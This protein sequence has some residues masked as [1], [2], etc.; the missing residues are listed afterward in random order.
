MK[1]VI[2]KCYGGFSLS[3]AAYDK[4]EVEFD[5]FGYLDNED[6]GIESQ[7]DLAYRADPRVIAVIEELGE[8]TSSGSMSQLSIVE[9]PKDVKWEIEEYDGMERIREISRSWG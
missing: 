6:M 9:I 5:G 4:L 3:K 1:V 7:E 8:E 2:N